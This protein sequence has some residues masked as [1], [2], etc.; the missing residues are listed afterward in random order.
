M[1]K[2]LDSCPEA[3]PVQKENS[4]N[5]KEEKSSLHFPPVLIAFCPLWP[6]EALRI[7]G[8]ALF[9]W[10]PLSFLFCAELFVFKDIY[11]TAITKSAGWFC[12][13]SGKNVKGCCSARLTPSFDVVTENRFLS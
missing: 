3:H 11:V 5:R 7:L 6:A 8:G 10:L 13:P 4:N 12:V 1:H 2:S 9:S